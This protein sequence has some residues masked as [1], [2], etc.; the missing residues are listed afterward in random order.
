VDDHLVSP[1][2]LSEN[3]GSL[4]WRPGPVKVGQI[5]KNTP[6]LWRSPREPLTQMKYFF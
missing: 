4:D 6:T 1:K 3:F 2:S 5:F